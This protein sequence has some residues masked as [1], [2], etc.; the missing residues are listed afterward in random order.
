MRPLHSAHS[1]GEGPATT[2]DDDLRRRLRVRRFRDF[3]G[4]SR[5]GIPAIA[6]SAKSPNT[7][8]AAS[9]PAT[10]RFFAEATTAHNAAEAMAFR[11]NSKK[12]TNQVSCEK[13]PALP[14]KPAR[15]KVPQAMNAR[16]AS[17]LRIV[18]PW[19]RGEGSTPSMLRRAHLEG[20]ILSAGCLRCRRLPSR[21]ALVPGQGRSWGQGLA[22]APPTV[23]G[24][25]ARARR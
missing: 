16:V 6:I 9:Q 25:A 21:W 17:V 22:A 12:T 15:A 10:D 1:S 5:E 20:Q 19:D 4:E 8:P 7:K 24:K 18:F 23:P 3:F 11:A 13:E 14:V 2:F